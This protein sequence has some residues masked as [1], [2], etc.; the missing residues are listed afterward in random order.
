MAEFGGG[1]AS[2]IAELVIGSPYAHDELV[3][4]PIAI[5]HDF[6]RNVVDHNPNTG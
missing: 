4:V 6:L 5:A 1:I 2:S 3:P